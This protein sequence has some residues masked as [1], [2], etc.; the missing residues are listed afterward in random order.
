MIKLEQL[1]NNTSVRGA[2]PDVLVTV[3]SVQWHGRA[4]ERQKSRGFTSRP[5][6]SYFVGLRFKSFLSSRI[7]CAASR[8]ASSFS[9]SVL[10]MYGGDGGALV[11]RTLSLLRTSDR[12]RMGQIRNACAVKTR[13]RFCR[14]QSNHSTLFTNATNVADRPGVRWRRGLSVPDSTSSARWRSGGDSG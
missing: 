5:T 14:R 7:N 4:S 11:S 9:S 13:M 3:V 2:I 12:S 6:R 1:Q 10:G 8:N